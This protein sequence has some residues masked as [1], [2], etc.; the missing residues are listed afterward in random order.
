MCPGAAQP[1]MAAVATDH[2]ENK[3]P[4]RRATRR[5]GGRLRT[6][7]TDAD[8]LCRGQ[9]S[10]DLSTPQRSWID[11]HQSIQQF[12]RRNGH[13]TREIRRSDSRVFWYFD[14]APLWRP[15]D[16]PGSRCGRWSGS[17][18]CG[19]HGGQEATQEADTSGN[20]NR[21]KGSGNGGGGG[22]GGTGPTG[23]TCV[24]DCTGPF[25]PKDC[26]S[27]GCGGTCGECPFLLPICNPIIFTCEPII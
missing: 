2:S 11:R 5:R 1:N 19:R 25:G 7:I 9:Q 27:D 13:G 4:D 12:Q 18:R 17:A 16:R 22:G 3:S 23:P 21:G 24:P 15:A 20:K 8:R 14:A 6:T 26:G 10:N